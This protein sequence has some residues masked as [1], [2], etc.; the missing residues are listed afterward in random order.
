[1]L[2]PVCRMLS[3]LYAFVPSNLK[4]SGVWVSTTATRRWSQTR[5]GDVH[6][7]ILFQAQTTVLADFHL[8]DVNITTGD[9]TKEM[10]IHFWSLGGLRLH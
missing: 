9:N 10:Y 8:C 5:D 6:H 2:Q 4:P 3:L 7:V 1:M